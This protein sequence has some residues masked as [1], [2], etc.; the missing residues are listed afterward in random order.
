MRFAMCLLFLS[1]TVK[2]LVVTRAMPHMMRSS[3]PSMALIDDLIKAP[4]EKKQEQ[5]MMGR[6]VPTKMMGANPFAA[7]PEEKKFQRQTGIMSN[8]I[9]LALLLPA[10][11]IP[12]LVIALDENWSPKGYLL[13]LSPTATAA[14]G[15]VALLLLAGS[16]LLVQDDE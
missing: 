15:G 10:F 4:A 5:K 13:F 2:A 6:V 16:K 8:P 14:L 12:F 7:K 3:P 9:V 1:A 11:T